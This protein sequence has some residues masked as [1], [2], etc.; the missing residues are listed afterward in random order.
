[1]SEGT[2]TR[3]DL[4]RSWADS[5]A[6]TRD[7]WIARNQFFY[8]DDYAY[9][10]FVIR[11]GLRVLELGCG[12]GGLLD[13]VKPAFGVGVDFSKEMI[14]GARAKYPHLQFVE[15]DVEDKAVIERLPGPFDVIIISDT[16]GLLDDCETVV[17]SLHAVSTPQ[18]RIVL[19]YYNRLW[20]GV[21]RAGERLGA[22]MRQDSRNWLSTKDIEN[23]LY[24]SGF[25]VVKS[26]WR[27]IMPKRLF[28]IGRFLNRFVGPLPLIRR[29][30][31]RTYVIARPIAP[32]SDV[33][34]SVSVVIPCRNERGNIENAVTR[35]PA[36]GREQEIVFVEGHSKDG[37]LEEIH[38]VIDAYPNKNIKVFV[39]DGKGKGDAV[40]K[41]F[42]NSSGE[43]LMILDAD[44]TVEPESLPRFYRALVDGKGEFINGTRLVYPLEDESM[45]FLNLWANRAFSKIFSWLL[46]QRFTDTL[47]GTK[48]LTR[49]SY[50]ALA[51]NRHYF[52]DFDPFGD[53]DLILGASKLNLYIVEIPIRYQARAYGETQISRFRH[54]W[55]LLR[56]VVFA[57]RKL[58]AL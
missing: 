21:I 2:H 15:G 7:A 58:K 30:C 54:G 14:E 52:G 28:G 37:T 3:K 48:V 42:T 34:P 24:L 41:G 31:L 17:R 25:Q 40:R 12:T 29:L 23:L 26:E 45:R 27:Q 55:M 19:S 33:E 47:C 8:E 16:I 11:P 20:E 32:S 50:D 38:R 5:V 1:M 4:I 10:Q 18:T 13:A 43:I 46:N 44:L 51:A 49:Q 36:F 9:M 57:Y 22:K 53:F 56:M 6:G 39:Q 35:L